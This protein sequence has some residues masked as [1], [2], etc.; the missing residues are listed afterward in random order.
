MDEQT[1]GSHC[2][3]YLHPNNL[4]DMLMF[5]SYIKRVLNLAWLEFKITKGFLE[6]DCR[7][8]ET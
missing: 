4:S 7:L 1:W 2:E 5:P 3:D 6:A 8:A